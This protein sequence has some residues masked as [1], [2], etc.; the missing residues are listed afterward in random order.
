MSTTSEPP[1][2]TSDAFRHDDPDEA[3]EEGRVNPPLGEQQRTLA[4]A[5][6]DLEEKAEEIV[7]R[8]QGVNSFANADET[9]AMIEPPSVNDQGGN[10][11]TETGNV[12]TDAV[13]NAFRG[14]KRD[15]DKETPR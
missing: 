15:D 4:G 3:M 11:R 13:A 8:E 5:P 1:L 9:D 7:K 10:D 2:G 14:T 6:R 12:F